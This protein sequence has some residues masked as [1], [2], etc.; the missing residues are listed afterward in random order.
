MRRR[1]SF[2]IKSVEERLGDW[3][4]RQPEAVARQA[5]SLALRRDMV[6]LLMFVRDNKVVGT[7]STGN[8]PLKSAREVTVRFVNP[9]Q[10]ETTIG[11]QTFQIRSEEELWPL[12]FLHILGEISGLIKTGRARRWRLTG[13]GT[14][15]LNTAPMLQVY[16]LLAAWWHKGNWLVAYP[17][18]GMGGALPVVFPKVTLANLRSLTAGTY[19]SFNKFAD[20]L[21]GDTGLT[22]T[23]QDSSFASLTLRGSVERMVINVLSDFGALKCRYRREPL[24]RGTISRLAAFKITPWG[25]ALLNAMTALGN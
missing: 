15:F 16:F 9:P 6:T 20:Q 22:W 21:I 14:R 13:Q 4:E 23:A 3:L 18:V 10:L 17:F 5:E 25:T 12:Y 1:T 8:M 11:K 2:T 7:Q 19:A 24:G